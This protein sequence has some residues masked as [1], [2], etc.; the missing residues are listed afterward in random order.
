MLRF[1]KKSNLFCA[2]LNFCAS[3]I[4]F[5]PGMRSILVVFFILCLSACSRG[6]NTTT[7]QVVSSATLPARQLPDSSATPAPASR[8]TA[9][10]NPSPSATAVATLENGAPP[11]VGVLT[12]SPTSPTQ[13][14]ATPAENVTGGIPDP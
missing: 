6:S 11:A 10:L 7:P 2:F 5:L 12:V 4:V 9:T 3:H 14:A 1:G 13:L 8:T